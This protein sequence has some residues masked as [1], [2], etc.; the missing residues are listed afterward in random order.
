MIWCSHNTTNCQSLDNCRDVKKI[1][2]MWVGS[3][4]TNVTVGNTG[5]LPGGSR[6]LKGKY[7]CTWQ[8]SKLSA[9]TTHGKILM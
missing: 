3:T 6:V 2:V 4:R 5:S 8:K 7:Q 1:A 9:I